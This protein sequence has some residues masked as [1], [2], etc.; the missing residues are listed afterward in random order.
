SLGL[1]TFLSN[2]FNRGYFYFRQKEVGLYVHDN[3]KVG[4]R[5]T[6]DLGVRWDRWSPYSEKLNRLVN[7]DASTFENKFEVITPHNVRM[8]SLQGIPPTVL[9]SWARRG[10]TWKTANEAGFPGALLPADNNNF[11]PR[12]GAAFRLTDKWAI[13]A[14]YGE[15]FWTMP[16]S[17]ILQA[18]RTNPPL[19]L[20]YTNPIG[21]LDTTATF[22][23][24]T[25]PRPEFYIG[26]AAVDTNGIILLPNTSQSFR[27]W[28]HRDWKDNRAQAWHFTLEREV[29][30]NT[31]LRLSYIGDHGRDLEQK[32]GLNS[33][34]TE[35]NYQARTGLARPAVTDLRRIN[36]NWNFD[37]TTNHTGYSNT[38]S[39]QAEVERRYT[40]GLAFQ[41]FYTFTRSLT[42]TDSDGFS[43]GGGN[44]NSGTADFLVPESRSIL[45]APSMSYDERL[46]LGYQNSTRIPAHRVRYNAIWDLPFGTG[47]LVGR[48]AGS[49]LNRVIGGWQ[50]AT[51]GDWR[52]GNWLSVGTGAYLFGD[53]TLSADERL[54]LTFNSR[55]Q[56]LWWR[57]YFTPTQASNVD[58]QALQGLV[59][60]NPGDRIYRPVGANF[61]NQILQRLADGTNRLTSIADNVSWNARGFLRG[62]GFWNVDAS[63]FKTVPIT[64]KVNARVTVDFFNFFNHP[65][66]AD[67]AGGTG[68]QDLSLQNNEPRIIQFSLRIQF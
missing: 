12:I 29:L 25:A 46:R 15:Y 31:G 2:Q 24:R 13:R 47:K 44:F 7:V 35:F 39:L 10:L 41:W 30:R 66:D 45:G 62:P 53:P 11:G 34:E 5:L 59:P 6:L 17:Q 57:G 50:L 54:L 56:R 42:T 9:A 27:M 38:H 21:S 60:L 65:V 48:N 67:P 22:A 40:N 37:Q 20:R 8:E 36:P 14:S 4:R 26:R 43:S 16:L 3:W 61:D 63:L 58:Q 23:V 51:I 55:P 18:A 1:P 19:N 32:Y 33:L 64:E 52:S 49:G 28:D 68:L